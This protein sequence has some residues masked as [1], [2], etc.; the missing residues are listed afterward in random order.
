MAD[1]SDYPEKNE[2]IEA[3]CDPQSLHA[4]LKDGRHIENPLWWY[5]TLLQASPSARN[6]IELNIAGLH[7]PEID[8]DISIEGMLNG[9]KARNAVDP[10]AVSE[11]AE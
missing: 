4:R 10:A 6:R 5:P 11:A 8:E 2:P 1:H 7:W 9:Y 3:W